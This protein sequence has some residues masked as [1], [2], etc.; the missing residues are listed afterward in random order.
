MPAAVADD[1]ACVIC[2]EA[3]RTHALLPCG[4]HCLCA[5]SSSEYELHAEW[6]RVGEGPK[7]PMCRV[8]VRDAQR[9]WG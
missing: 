4:H 2:L 7:C 9:V 1:D 6:E 5:A 8:P 3:Q